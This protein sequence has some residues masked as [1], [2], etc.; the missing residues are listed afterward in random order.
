MCRALSAG[1]CW[2]RGRSA[3][4]VSRLVRWSTP[5]VIATR[6]WSP[7]WRVLSIRSP[8]AGRSWGS[9]LPPQ[10]PGSRPLLRAD[11]TRS[12]RDRT[13]GTRRRRP[14]HGRATAAGSRHHLLHRQRQRP[15]PRACPQLGPLARPTQRPAYNVVRQHG[16]DV[17]HF[18]EALIAAPRFVA[19]RQSA[20]AL[21][22]R[23]GHDTLA[24]GSARA[25]IKPPGETAG[26][27]AARAFVIPAVS[28]SRPLALAV[29]SG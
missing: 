8:A 18:Q 21:R 5:S 29:V 2:P 26:T 11:R 10:G 9:A 27:Y 16:K 17:R 28:R 14:R 24:A 15:R 23:R 25:R 12:R 13:L 1:R 22:R 7:T 6:I 19:V 4:R 3:R 20:A